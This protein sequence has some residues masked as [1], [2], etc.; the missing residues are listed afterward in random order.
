MTLPCGFWRPILPGKK[1]GRNKSLQ[2]G[3]ET[4]KI[5]SEE[6]LSYVRPAGKG[7]K[8]GPGPLAGAPFL[9]KSKEF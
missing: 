7:K 9:W 2:R 6:L 5:F 1:S 4:W 8:W 3:S